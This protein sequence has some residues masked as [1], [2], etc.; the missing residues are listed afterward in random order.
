LL[1]LTAEDKC[2]PQ[3]LKTAALER[4]R[5]NYRDPILARQGST[6][7]IHVAVLSVRFR[8]TSVCYLTVWT[9]R[10]ALRGTDA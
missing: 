10:Y 3:E 8:T 9:L 4:I 6:D 5:V 2:Y 1:S 7:Q